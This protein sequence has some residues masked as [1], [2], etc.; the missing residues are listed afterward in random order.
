MRVYFGSRWGSIPVALGLAAVPVAHPALIPMIGVPSHLLWW[1]H[2]LPVALLTRA[3][4]WRG[5]A[6]SIV[7]CTASVVAGERLFGAGYGQPADWATALALAV[8]LALTNGLVAGFALFVRSEQARSA[9]LAAFPEHSP[10]PTLESAA[11]GSVLYANDAARSA[12]LGVDGARLEDLLPP[13]HAAL[14]RALSPPNA[15][16]E[17]REH[18]VGGRTFVWCYAGVPRSGNVHLYGAD[19]T[20]QRSYQRQLNRSVLYDPVTGLPNRRLFSDRLS[21]EAQAVV[22]FVLEVDRLEAIRASLGAEAVD[23]VLSAVGQRLAAAVGHRVSLAHLGPG[24][25]AY[26]VDVED[27]EEVAR[28]MLDSL[29]P[30]LSLAGTRLHPCGRVGVATGQLEPVELIRRA[31]AAKS[32]VFGGAGWAMFDP[33]LDG[34]SGCRVQAE[35]AL[36]AAIGRREFVPYYQTIVDARTGELRGVEALAR[37]RHPTRGVLSPAHF[38]E[39]AEQ[40]GLIVPLTLQLAELAMAQVSRWRRR[41]PGLT[42]SL[43]LAPSHLLVDSLPA[44]LLRL[45]GESGLPAE[46]LQL[47]ITESEAVQRYEAVASL[48]DLGV[49]IA[50]DDFGTG[51]SSLA[52]L[53][54]LTVHT[55]KID[56]SFVRGLAAQVED[57]AIVRTVVTLAQTLGL[58]VVAEGV[59]TEEQRAIL[60]ELGV[61]DAQGYLFSRPLPEHE[62]GL[63]DAEPRLS[64]RAAG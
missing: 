18:A 41:H 62:T 2:V 15:K 37:W 31:R 5:A 26:G 59:E 63:D 27:V 33:D 64:N 16:V 49:R 39:L 30:P 21:H 58:S 48:A 36:R 32:R 56:Q 50:I 8:A 55:L 1:V 35:E 9:K 4:G 23:L 51:Y 12:L 44:D 20:D 61:Q 10:R 24:F 6:G 7:F 34:A 42:L 54:R 22:L 45:L 14:C 43:N 53:K 11:D 17:L 57:R 60:V 47:E 28:A 52:H 40:T 25:G 3:F 46:A 19:V 13:D 38:I 29:T